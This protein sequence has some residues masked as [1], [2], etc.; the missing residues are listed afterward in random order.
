MGFLG[1]H[2][3]LQSNMV[4]NGNYNINLLNLIQRFP[5]I[6]EITE[7]LNNNDIRYGMFCSGVVETVTGYR[8]ASDIDLLVDSEHVSKVATLILDASACYQSDRIQ[9]SLKNTDYIDF[10]GQSIYYDKYPFFLTDI[11]WENTYLIPVAD[12]EIRLLHPIETILVKAIQQRGIEVGKYDWEDARQLAQSGVY[13]DL[14]YTSKRLKEIKADARIFDFLHSINLQVNDSKNIVHQKESE[15]ISIHHI[16]TSNP[17]L[18][19]L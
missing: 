17:S 10:F 19:H 6:L 15:H 3:M 4:L 14:E 13:Y 2:D 5:R 18:V 12:T 1:T 11:V 8:Q 9:I 16:S 7:T